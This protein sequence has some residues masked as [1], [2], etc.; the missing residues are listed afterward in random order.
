MIKDDDNS[1]SE[2]TRTIDVRERHLA[3]SQSAMGIKT[4][5]GGFIWGFRCLFDDR[6][7]LVCS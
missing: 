7:I 6:K 5:M 3:G 4:P 2:R 1:F